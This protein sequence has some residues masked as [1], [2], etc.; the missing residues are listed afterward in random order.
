MKGRLYNRRVMIDFLSELVQA[1]TTTRTGELAAAQVI[2]NEL[3]LSA[4]EARIDTW[5]QARANIQARIRSQGRKPA[6][7]FACHLDVVGPGDAPWK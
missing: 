4:I 5:D 1:E 3:A 7:L 6:L 2:S